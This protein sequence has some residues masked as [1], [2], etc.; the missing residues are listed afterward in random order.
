MAVSVVKL[1]GADV[2]EKYK[3]QHEAVWAVLVNGELLEYCV[4]EVEANALQVKLERLEEDRKPRFDGPS[5]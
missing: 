5:M 2:P 4:S 3:G 1:Q